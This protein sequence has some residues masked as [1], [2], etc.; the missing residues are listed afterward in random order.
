MSTIKHPTR[1]AALNH[2]LRTLA[3]WALLRSVGDHDVAT[4]LTLLSRKVEEL[5]KRVNATKE[6]LP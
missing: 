6:E 5:R 1:K 2:G 3:N 4:T